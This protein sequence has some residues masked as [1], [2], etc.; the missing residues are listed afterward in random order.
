MTLILTKEEEQRAI[1]GMVDILFSYAYNNRT[2]EGE[3]TVNV[4]HL[5][6]KLI[7]FYLVFVFKTVFSFN[8][9]NIYVFNVSNK[10]TRKMCETGSKLRTFTEGFR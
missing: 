7:V 8:P 10:N 4:N 1:L 3:N 2:T 6:V 5:N 9:A